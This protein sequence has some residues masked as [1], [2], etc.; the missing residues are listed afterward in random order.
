MNTL[1]TWSI[2]ILQLLAANLAVLNVS[3]RNYTTCEIVPFE[4]IYTSV[5]NCLSSSIATCLRGFINFWTH[6]LRFPTPLLATSWV[7]TCC[8]IVIFLNVSVISNKM[9]YCLCFAYQSWFLLAYIRFSWLDFRQ[10]RQM[11][12]RHCALE[13]FFGWFKATA[14]LS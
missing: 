5:S 9:V 13:E 10:F 1:N 11:T 3:Q 4:H 7:D 12:C 14:L 6:D 2:E 8:R